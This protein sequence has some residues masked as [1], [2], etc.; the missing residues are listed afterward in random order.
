[1]EKTEENIL[2]LLKRITDIENIN[3]EIVDGK[4][5]IDP[6]TVGIALLSFLM[7]NENALQNFDSELKLVKI[8]NFEY[9]KESN[10]LRNALARAGEFAREHSNEEL[11]EELFRLTYPLY[12]ITTEGNV[13]RVREEK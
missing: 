3:V 7:T 4:L 1:M 12:G 5:I 11:A 13:V 10:D 8:E 6:S 2:E 9:Q